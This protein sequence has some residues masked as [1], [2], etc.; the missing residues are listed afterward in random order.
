MKANFDG[1]RRNATHNMNDLANELKIFIE[2][3][4]ELA[5]SGYMQAIVEA[6]NK[7][8]HSVDVFNCIYD[9]DVDGD[10]NDLSDALHVTRLDEL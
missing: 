5:D 8:A 9:D 3:D 2:S 4:D 1:M 6:F 10:I 7:A